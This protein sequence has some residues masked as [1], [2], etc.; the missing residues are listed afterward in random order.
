MV[1]NQNNVPKQGAV[2]M[3][4]NHNNALIDA[5]LIATKSGRFS[6]FLT[7]ASVFKKPLANTIL[8]GL[9]MLPV[10]RIRDGWHT[11]SNNNSIFTTCSRLLS[12]GKTVALFPEGNHNMKR[13]VR[14]LSKGFI[15]IVFETLEKYPQSNLKIVPIGLNFE[16]AD[17]FA[18]SVS[19]Y[20][21]KPIDRHIYE[22]ND[23]NLGA[24]VLKEEVS[25]ALKKLTTH[26]PE[27]NYQSTLD[28]LNKLHANFLNPISVNSC[29]NSN[30]TDCQFQKKPLFFK[31]LKVFFKWLLICS[32]LVPWIIWRLLIK[33]K[34]NEVEFVATFRFA[35][36]ITLVPIWILTV[37]F[38]LTM[39]MGGLVGVY[40]LLG[41]LLL[42]VL[43]VKL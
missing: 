10:Y 16:K 20:F 3:V 14:K 41:V 18:D 43:A 2:L 32:L 36:A 38:T 30:F 4:S 33:P 23:K 31:G 25:K 42:A 19:I 24:T 1:V 21:G 39:I 7:R 35:I 22:L 15:R 11:I 27:E 29:I 28:R 34:I 17:A 37:S 6:Y 5:L 13:T 26:I 40:F 9:N 8:R 12:K